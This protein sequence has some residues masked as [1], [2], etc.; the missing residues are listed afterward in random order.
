[1]K[2][3]MAFTLE[4]H[5][6]ILRVL[7]TECTIYP[8]FNPEKIT[9]E[10]GDNIIGKN[11]LAIWDTG[12]TSS[13]ITKRVS[14]ELRLKTTGFSVMK[15]AGG[16]DEVP[17]HIVNIGLPN[18]VGFEFVSVS[19]GKI[20][21]ADVLIGMDII[22]QGDFIITNTEGKTTFSFRIPS[23]E[24]ID[25]N[26]VNNEFMHY[27]KIHEAWLKHGNNKCPCS[28]GKTWDNCHGKK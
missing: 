9:K 5:E 19:E 24:K 23:I 6:G 16:E 27:K 14:D 13:V 18:K 28:S 1:M 8:G 17:M 26:E 11:Y 20:P 7:K 12:A 21:D 4:S 22:T 10:Q 15:H 2:N 25:F 3:N